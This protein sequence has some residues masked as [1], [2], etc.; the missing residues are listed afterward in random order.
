MAWNWVGLG[1]IVKYIDKWIGIKVDVLEM[2]Y[3]GIHQLGLAWDGPI[4]TR[5]V[6]IHWNWI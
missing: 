6:R 5:L 1:W 3:I 4:G 2:N